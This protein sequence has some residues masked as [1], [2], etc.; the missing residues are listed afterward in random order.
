MMKEHFRAKEIEA[1]IIKR[2]LDAQAQLISFREIP[3]ASPSETWKGVFAEILS[4]QQP[5]P[6]YQD[7]S[8]DGFMLPVPEVTKRARTT[9]P[10]SPN[11]P[12]NEHS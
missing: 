10:A 1:E 8:P 5:H 4:F 9:P 6:D 3:G 2:N 11:R 7:W 12:I